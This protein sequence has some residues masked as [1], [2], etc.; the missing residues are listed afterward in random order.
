[1]MTGQIFE[2][3]AR[4]HSFEIAAQVMKTL[5]ATPTTL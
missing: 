1:M 3:Q 2:H 5:Q 4:L